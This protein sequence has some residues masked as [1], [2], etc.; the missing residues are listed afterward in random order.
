MLGKFFFAAVV[1]APCVA[2]AASPSNQPATMRQFTANQTKIFLL[3]QTAQIA[4]LKAQIAQSNSQAGGSGGSQAFA[5]SPAPQSGA[6]SAAGSGLAQIV[7]IAG[8]RHGVQALI[9]LPDGSE[10]LAE[11]GEALPGGYTVHDVTVSGVHV[12]KAGNLIGLPWASSDEIQNA[13]R[14][15]QSGPESG[16][17]PRSDESGPPRLPGATPGIAPLPAYEPPASD[18]SAGRP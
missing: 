16:A 1:L 5:T 18:H 2:V 4:R 15:R 10:V 7:S 17:N 14:S 9:R 13:S 3:Q 8:G 6:A 12:M 11:R